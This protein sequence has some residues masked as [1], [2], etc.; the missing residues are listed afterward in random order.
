MKRTIDRKQFY[1]RDFADCYEELISYYPRYY[2]EV[3]EMNAIL[4]ANG[5]L[6]DG[7]QDAIEQVYNNAFIDFMD[8]AAVRQMEIFLSI[9]LDKTRTLDERRRLIK[10]F[11]AGFGRV[12]AT[13]LKEMI[14]AY[15]NAGVEVKFEP[16][17]AAGNNMLYINFER[18]DE[19]TLYMSDILELLSR[20]IPAHIAYTPIVTYKRAVVVKTRKTNYVFDYDLTGTKPDVS[21]K[22]AYYIAETVTET[23][24]LP[25][26]TDYKQ[27]AD[28]DNPTG[29][30]PEPASLAA[31]IHRAT[32]TQAAHTPHLTEYPSTAEA[33]MPTGQTPEPAMLGNAARVVTGVGYTVT[34][35]AE[36][37]PLCGQYF[38]SQS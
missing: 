3:R 14:N 19:A 7:T 22:G 28:V 20:K 1:S 35:C 10:S 32:V 2:R 21:T 33:D 30:N 24:R 34:E 26:V 29:T 9:N 6:L 12:S 11:F 37:Y 25:V 17:D 15:T 13:L 36:T 5:K 16:F 18:G 23:N 27:A 31:Y 38:A 4:K 8:E